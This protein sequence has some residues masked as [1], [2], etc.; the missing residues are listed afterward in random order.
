[1]PFRIAID[2]PAASGKSTVAKAVAK[3]IGFLY[4]DTG[5]LYRAMAYAIRQANIPPKEKVLQQFCSSCDLEIRYIEGEQHV[6]LEKE[7]IS[8]F[9][10]DEEIGNFA[11]QISTFSCIRQAL[12]DLQRKTGEK[13]N[14][15]ADGRDIGTCIF[16]DAELKI[17]LTAKTSVRALRRQKELGLK[18]PLEEIEENLRK[19]DRRDKSRE[20]APLKQAFDAIYLD[21][22]ELSREEIIEQIIQYYHQRKG[23]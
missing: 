16:P 12:F 23:I 7:D 6:F 20:I 9:L 11:S 2:G 13:N 1:M 15:I 3:K 22:S 10:K 21:S 5:A 14:I 17:Y 18:E 4:L 8:L 19:R